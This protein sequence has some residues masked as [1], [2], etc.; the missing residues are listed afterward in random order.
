MKTVFFDLGGVLIDF[1][2]E[3]MCGQ[4]AK[5]AGI[6]EETI[7]KIFF[8]DKIQ[9]LYEKGLIDSQYL[10][11]KLSQVAKKQLDFHHVM[12]AI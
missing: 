7:Q 12:I 2:H 6:P 3:K 9:D 1:S 11:F 4:L 8:E 5:V 10:H